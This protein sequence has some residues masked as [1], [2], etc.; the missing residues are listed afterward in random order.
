M[1]GWGRG[2]ARSNS[3][4]RISIS[5]RTRD[6][7]QTCAAASWHADV[8]ASTNGAKC[9]PLIGMAR[10][11]L[12]TCPSGCAAPGA[13]CTSTMRLQCTSRHITSGGSPRCCGHNQPLAI[14]AL[15]IACHRSAAPV[16]AGSG[17]HPRR[18]YHQ[19]WRQPQHNHARRGPREVVQRPVGRRR[20]CSIRS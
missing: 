11:Q 6:V 2:A 16:V 8:H 5:V 4:R 1:G 3:L 17:R 20:C 7:E 15:C 18:S 14:R 19:R 9:N 12:S 13:A 10:D